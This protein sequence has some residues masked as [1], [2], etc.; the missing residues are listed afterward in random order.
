MIDVSSVNLAAALFTIASQVVIAGIV[1]GWFLDRYHDR[2]TY[3]RFLGER[4]MWFAFFAAII[5]TVGSLYYSEIIGYE[6]CVLCWWQRIFLY[7]QVVILGFALVK[8]EI[9]HAVDYALA[10][11]AVGAV[12]ALYNSYIQY[13]G[14]EFVPCPANGPSCAIRYVYEFGYITIPLMSLTLFALIIG[15][16]YTHKKVNSG[17]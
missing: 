9:R 17:Q 14:S 16:L 10:L 2:P 8:R 15:L 6:P 13:G 4:G 12:V 5:G 7:P 3:L 11:S 1:I